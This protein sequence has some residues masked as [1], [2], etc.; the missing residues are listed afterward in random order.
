MGAEGIDMAE[1]PLGDR[2]RSW[3]LRLWMQLT[4]TEWMVVSAILAVLIALLLPTIQ[5][6]S[7]GTIK[8]ERCRQKL[9]QIGL[10]LR[11]YYYEYRHFPPQ[12]L[13]DA[14][15]RPSHSWRVLLLPYLGREDL[16]SQY[17][18][19]EPW[20]GP[21][22]ARLGAAAADLFRCPSAATPDNWMAALTSYVAIAG[23]GTAWHGDQPRRDRDFRDGT[24]FS[25]VVAEIADSTIHWM[26]PRD[27][28]LNSLSPTINADAATGISSPHRGGAY[29]LMG[30]GNPR[31]LP[32]TLSAVMLRALLTIAGDESI[33]DEF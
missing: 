21:H 31:F 18:F 6:S 3:L 26:E 7:T 13:V 19:D 9:Q 5:Q 24:G 15:G 33:P 28:E 2:R 22:N 20:N 17:R 11:S 14:E 10:A 12:Y 27:L 1:R 23:P 29:G 8:R 32:E 16:Y 25:L 4:A 30:N